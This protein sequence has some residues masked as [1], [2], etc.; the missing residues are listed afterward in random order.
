MTVMAEAPPQQL[1]APRRLR[2]LRPALFPVELENGAADRL[3]PLLGRRLGA[4]EP[5][6]EVVRARELAHRHPTSAAAWARLAQAELVEHRLDEAVQAARAALAAPASGEDEAAQLAAALSL[7]ACE[8]SD[9]AEAALTR[10]GWSDGP[11]AVVAAGLAAQR[12]AFDEARR[13][14][15]N[16]RSGS[17]W[18]LRG[19]IALHQRDY[20]TAVKAYRHAIRATGPTPESLTNMGLA[21]AALGRLDRAIRE[22]YQA[23]ALHPSRIERVLF[24]L[25]TYL[26]SVGEGDAAVAVIEPL[27]KSASSAEAAFVQARLYLGLGDP[28]SALRVLRRTRTQMWADLDSETAAE[29]SANLAFVRGRLGEL[30]AAQVTRELISELQRTEYRS[31]R[32]AALLPYVLTGFS[33][34]DRLRA[35][36]ARVREEH[37]EEPLYE[38]ETH[39]AVLEKRFDVATTLAIEWTDSAFFDPEPATI[40]TYL[41]CNIQQDYERAIA[42]GTATLSRM[43]AAPRLAHNVAYA[44]ALAGETAEA[45]RHLIPDEDE[46]HVIATRG[47]I[48]I[49]EGDPEGGVGEY[50]RALEVALQSSDAILPLLVDLHARFAFARFG[51]ADDVEWEGADLEPRSEW[52]DDPAVAVAI[53]MLRRTG[54]GLPPVLGQLA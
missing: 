41:L 17:A 31:L 34:G 29:L 40:A 44:L 5:P 46:V 23:L 25:A 8:E 1:A 21:H 9:D 45:R 10:I 3:D 7:A 15:E 50:Q 32:I 37:P 52:A 19:W 27:V 13:R 35:T 2:P 18:N 33:D 20:R 39:L 47:L 54:V 36:V 6:R 53:E 11:T 49:R 38:L 51:E 42:I 48:L 14:L 24:N 30:S 16:Q 22:T 12:G 26:I 4:D 28:R 43:P